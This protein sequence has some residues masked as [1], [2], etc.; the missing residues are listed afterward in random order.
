LPIPGANDYSLENSHN[1]FTFNEHVAAIF[2]VRC[3][4]K[5]HDLFVSQ[6]DHGIGPHRPPRGDVT[7]RERHEQEQNN[8]KRHRQDVGAALAEELPGH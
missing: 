4:S 1:P 7:G 2:M 5:N 6:R 3:G 8:G